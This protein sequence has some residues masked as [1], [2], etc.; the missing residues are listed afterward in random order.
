MLYSTEHRK[1]PVSGSTA[2]TRPTV[3]AGGQFS[4]TSISTAT[5]IDARSLK[6]PRRRKRG[7]TTGPPRR[8]LRPPPPPPPHALRALVLRDGT[9]GLTSTGTVTVSV[10]P[11]LR[12]GARAEERE[13]GRGRGPWGGAGVVPGAGGPIRSREAATTGAVY[14]SIPPSPA[15]APQLQTVR[16]S[17]GPTA[18]LVLLSHLQPSSSS[19]SSSTSS[20]LTLYVPLVLRDGTSGLTS[21]GTV[22]VSVC[23]CLRGGARAE[24]R[25][26]GRGRGTLGAGPGSGGEEEDGGEQQG[27]GGG[28]GEWEWEREAVC[29][30]QQSSLP[31]P[32]LSTAALLAIL[33]CVATLLGNITLY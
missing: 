1:S 2:L 25:E 28:G 17:G 31:S 9:S 30:P 19:S 6:G 3:Q 10:C 5:R 12:G 27:G 20:T 32:G 11:C 7:S 4:D 33:A 26:K 21:T 8:R 18:S 15:R 29:L 23:P 22:T 24:E 16:D 14:S 13:K